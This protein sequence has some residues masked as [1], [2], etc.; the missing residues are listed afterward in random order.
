MMRILNWLDADK[1]YDYKVRED[2]T[3]RDVPELAGKTMIEVYEI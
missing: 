2:D 3:C 1:V